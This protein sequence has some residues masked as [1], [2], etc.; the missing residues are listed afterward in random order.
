LVTEVQFFDNFVGY[1]RKVE[2][3]VFQFGS[4][5]DVFEGWNL[6]GKLYFNS[7]FKHKVKCRGKC[8]DI[9]CAYGIRIGIYEYDHRYT[10]IRLVTKIAGLSKEDIE[11]K[12]CTNSVE[13]E[14]SDR[15]ISDHIKF[16]TRKV[17]NENLK[18]LRFDNEFFR[19]GL[20][21]ML[22]YGCI[23]RLKYGKI[24]TFELF[25][26]VVT[27][28]IKGDVNAIIVTKDIPPPPG[29]DRKGCYVSHT[30]TDLY[31]FEVLLTS[32]MTMDSTYK[33]LVMW[34]IRN[35][36]LLPNNLSVVSGL[37][38]PTGKHRD[39][40]SRYDFTTVSP[41]VMERDVYSPLHQSY[42]EIGNI[43][44]V[45]L[46]K[47]LVVP[48]NISHMVCDNEKQINLNVSSVVHTK[49]KIIILTGD[50]LEMRSCSSLKRKVSE[51]YK[52]RY[53][54]GYLPESIRGDT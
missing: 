31:K 13:G 42:D 49:H 17:L 29:L 36:D 25:N 48:D 46:T 7:S 12:L 44:S 9:D 39:V 3:T 30:Y 54:D 26:Y 6:K 34:P 23:V 19:S 16:W 5:V 41:V 32:R 53:K 52:T 40:V 8:N 50:P 21:L 35:V 15:D 10:M 33:G 45:G 38:C 22:D 20:Q 24:S 27:F 28:E 1:F 43:N 18:L 11:A 14:F 51:E 4:I 37:V 47:S 2:K